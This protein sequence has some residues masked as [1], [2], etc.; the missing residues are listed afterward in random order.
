MTHK[1]NGNH[2]REL[3]LPPIATD[4]PGA[5]EILRMWAASGTCQQVVLRAV[6]GDPAAWGLALVDIARHAAKA[7]GREGRD[8]VEVLR[9]IREFFDAEWDNPT[10]EPEDITDS[11]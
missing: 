5:I 4:D 3:E 6:W 8:P 1:E 10:E 9:R 2:R 11:V 7:Y